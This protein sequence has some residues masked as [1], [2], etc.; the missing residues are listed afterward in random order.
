[1]VLGDSLPTSRLLHNRGK[2]TMR[3][4]TVTE[5]ALA[6][7]LVVWLWGE[8]SQHR[9]LVS[10]WTERATNDLAVATVPVGSVLPPLLALN[11]RGLARDVPT[12]GKTLVLVYSDTCAICTVNWQQWNRLRKETGNRGSR[13][14][15]LN[16]RGRDPEEYR[17]AYNTAHALFD[18]D[19]VSILAYRFLYTPQT[20]VL[21]TG[22][23]VR[24]VWMGALRDS[25]RDEIHRLLSAPD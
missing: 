22:G 6:V 9:L 24:G 5:Y 12:S 25:Q 11:E 21:G 18:P 2:G 1:M 13:V 20:L 17:A 8:V 16:I 14:V 19:P 15:L 10:R 3:H 23:V 7:A 4:S